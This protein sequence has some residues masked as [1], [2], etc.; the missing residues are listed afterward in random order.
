MFL[1]YAYNIYGIQEM[2]SWVNKYRTGHMLM[3]HDL[4]YVFE[5]NCWLRR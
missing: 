5:N 3:E 4:D 2:I 1:F